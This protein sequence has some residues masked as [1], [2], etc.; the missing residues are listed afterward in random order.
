[1]YTMEYYLVM[2]RNEIKS[3]KVMWINIDPAIQS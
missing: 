3:V 2:K 1:M